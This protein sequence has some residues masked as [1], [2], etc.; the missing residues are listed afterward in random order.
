MN[1]GG[2]GLAAV[3][4]TV[5][6][7]KCIHPYLKSRLMTAGQAADSARCLADATERIFTLPDRV[8][9]TSKR[10]GLNDDRKERGEDTDG[11][12]LREVHACDVGRSVLSDQRRGGRDWFVNRFL[13]SSCH[14]WTQ[15]AG[16]SQMQS[17]FSSQWP[18]K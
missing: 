10:G 1:Y 2:L 7:D 4:E 16:V 3:H 13:L 15:F 9:G 6:N 18:P 11:N 14:M 5:I 17:W 8:G 12:G